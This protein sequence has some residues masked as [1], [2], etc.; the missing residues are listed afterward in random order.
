M[1]NALSAP[2]TRQ[3]PPGVITLA[4]DPLQARRID[5]GAPER[6]YRMGDPRGMRY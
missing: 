2:L 5:P 4:T 6:Y 3:N 1:R